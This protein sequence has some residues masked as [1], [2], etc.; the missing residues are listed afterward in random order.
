[1]LGGYI[2]RLWRGRQGLA[3]GSE[4]WMDWVLGVQ[5]RAAVK[6][7]KGGEGAEGSMSARAAGCWE[8]DSKSRS[9]SR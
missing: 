5:C 1:M 8:M 4:R 6:R 9:R 3:E 7:V 2:C